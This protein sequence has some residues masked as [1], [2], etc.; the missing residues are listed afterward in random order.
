[1]RRHNWRGA[2]AGRPRQQNVMYNS[3]HVPITIPGRVT[4]ALVRPRECESVIKTMGAVT[5]TEGVDEDWDE[6]QSEQVPQADA[7][8]DDLSRVIPRKRLTPA[9]T[10]LAAD[11]LAEYRQLFKQPRSQARHGLKHQSS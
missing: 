8:E 10:R 5:A 11:L 7:T 2:S 9:E 4:T 3:A 6:I 1:M